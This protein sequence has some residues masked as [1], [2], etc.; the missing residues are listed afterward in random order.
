M[1][2]DDG[3]WSVPVYSSMVSEVGYDPASGELIITW[4]NGK[5]SAY[6]GVPEGK[7]LELSKAASVGQMINSEIKPVYPHRYL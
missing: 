7:A 1:A 6:S 2:D 4:S 3:S 5:R